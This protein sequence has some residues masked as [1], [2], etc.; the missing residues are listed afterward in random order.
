MNASSADS[1]AIALSLTREKLGRVSILV[2]NAEEAVDI[3]PEY[4]PKI[5]LPVRFRADE[6]AR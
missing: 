5:P 3:W 4:D 1:I 2:N 6:R